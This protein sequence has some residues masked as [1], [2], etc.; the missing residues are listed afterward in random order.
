MLSDL[1]S[2]THT[3]TATTIYLTRRQAVYPKPENKNPEPYKQSRHN[4]SSLTPCGQAA[5]ENGVSRLWLFSSWPLFLSVLGFGGLG[6]LRVLGF[7]LRV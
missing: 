1:P 5:I 3:F 6:S 4:L 2:H 7:E